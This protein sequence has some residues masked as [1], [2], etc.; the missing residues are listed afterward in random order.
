MNAFRLRLSK[1]TAQVEVA[2]VKLSK[3]GEYAMRA[4]IELAHH[5]DAPLATGRIA[6]AQRIPKKFLEQILLAMKAAGLVTSRAGPRG[7]YVLALP[8]QEVTV[9]RV[10]SSVGEPISRR[11]AASGARRR[12]Q[13]DLVLEDIH[14]LIRARLDGVTLQQLAGNGIAQQEIEELMWYI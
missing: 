9:G 4:A 12:S 2:L 11:A 14:R 3:K 8:A 7:G 10:L 6:D 5:G 1:S 13:L